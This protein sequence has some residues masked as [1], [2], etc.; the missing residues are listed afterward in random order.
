M[1][2]VI[3]LSAILLVVP[4][5][6]MAQVP[7]IHYPDTEIA[8]HMLASQPPVRHCS[9]P[10]GRGLTCEIITGIWSPPAV[11]CQWGDREGGFWS[12][13]VT[14]LA[15]SYYY[16]SCH[17]TLRED[18]TTPPTRWLATCSQPRGWPSDVGHQ[19]NVDIHATTALWNCRNQITGRQ[20]HGQL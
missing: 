14:A 9:D 8:A 17:W 1:F 15:P 11:S 18:P 12:H 19:C 7:I 2:A 10:W 4:V 16:V 20:W 5:P 3:L 13:C 6:V